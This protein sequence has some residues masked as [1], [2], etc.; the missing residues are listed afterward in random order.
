M[1]EM[2]VGSNF[3][4]DEIA[5]KARTAAVRKGA[6]VRMMGKSIKKQGIGNLDLR[7]RDRDEGTR[8]DRGQGLRDQDLSRFW[9]W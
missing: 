1:K 3:W 2:V 8:K 9:V 6:K 5:D 4:A 7:G